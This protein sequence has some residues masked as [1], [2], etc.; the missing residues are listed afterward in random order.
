MKK[1]LKFYFECVS[2]DQQCVLVATKTSGI[3][4]CIKKSVA[5]RLREVILP[6]YSAVVRPHLECCVQFCVPQF[7]KD[8]ELLER[9][10]RRVIKMTGA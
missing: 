9:V 3:L 8:R 1:V 6:L 4:E 7:K 5:S 2:M 10:Q